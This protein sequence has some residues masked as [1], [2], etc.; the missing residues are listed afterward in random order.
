MRKSDSF[1]KGKLRIMFF[2][3][4]GHFEIAYS[5]LPSPSFSTPK[6]EGKHWFHSIMNKAIKY[7]YLIHPKMFRTKIYNN[8]SMPPFTDIIPMEN[9]S[10]P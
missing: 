7:I 3:E 9:Y 5:C 10:E 2:S 1:K 8:L 4:I 6:R